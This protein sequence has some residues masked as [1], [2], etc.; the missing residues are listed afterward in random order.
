MSVSCESAPG[1]FATT[2]RGG[3]FTGIY[4]IENDAVA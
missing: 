1:L 2:G 4:P 3:Q